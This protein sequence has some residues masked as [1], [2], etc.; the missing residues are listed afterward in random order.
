MKKNILL[1]IVCSLFTLNIVAQPY[2]NYYIQ[3]GPSDWQL[4]MS[5]KTTDDL[6]DLEKTVFISLTAGDE[7]YG[8]TTFGSATTAYYLAK[9]RAAVHAAKFADDM[10]NGGT[11][12][13]VPTA[14]TVTVGGKSMT[15]Y[16]YRSTVSY[17][18][19]LPD[20]GQSGAGYAGTANKSLQLLQQ[21]S[22]PNITSVDGVTTYTWAQLVSTILAIIQAE[23]GG[24][25]Q[26]W[27][28]AANLNTGVNPGDHSDRVYASTAAQQSVAATLW[29]GIDEF[30]N[31]HSSNLAANLTN[32]E[33][34]NA[35]GLFGV[36]DWNMLRELYP[37]KLN[38]VNR[39]WLPMDYNTIKRNPTG[40]ANAALPVTLYN[41]YGVLN[42]N[43]I[44]LHWKTSFEINSKEFIIEKSEDGVR[45]SY[46]ATVAAAG[47]SN[48]AK[49]YTQVDNTIKP[50]NYYRLKMVDNDGSFVY[51]N[52]VRVKNTEKQRDV[53]VLANV[54]SG[55]VQV[56]FA[57]VPKGQVALRLLD[58]AGRNV[59]SKI[60][61]NINSS[62]LNHNFSSRINSGVYIL[63]I[64]YNGTAYSQKLFIK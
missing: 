48:G 52:I 41:F 18:L 4:F 3:G 38:T 34:Q 36:A 29:V 59:E 37:S 64:M 2:V 17:F 60:Y 42:S 10:I 5:K 19:R 20:G 7:G 16:V 35:S 51:S 40:D 54:V 23:R 11:P 39:A 28:N 63:Q 8:N 6:S 32:G 9:E 30:I 46:F 47:F 22:I 55:D 14:Q 12:L 53:F 49:L 58:A 44:A 56:Q 45:F 27:L 43:N 13:A 33:Y 31:T 21:G 57:K 15:K 24:V 61:T 62:V 1:I 50:E 25:S 26:V